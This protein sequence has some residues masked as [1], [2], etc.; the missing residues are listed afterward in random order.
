MPRVCALDLG[1]SRVGVA[2]SDELGLLAHPRGVFDG[3]DQRKLLQAVKALADDEALDRILVGLPLHMSGRE[4]EGAKRARMLAQAIANA[5]GLEVE[6]LDE[7]LTTVEA[8]RSL[9]DSGVHGKK[10]KAHIDE[11]S[12]VVMLQAWLDTRRP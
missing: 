12:A 11:A 3:K 7:R 1:A 8:K 10:A 4:G 5:T 2:V 9:R 6:L